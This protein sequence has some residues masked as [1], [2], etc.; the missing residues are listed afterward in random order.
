MAENESTCTGTRT[1]EG[2]ALSA[3]LAP[4]S[5]PRSKRKCAA[6]SRRWCGSLV[7]HRSPRVQCVYL[8]QCSHAL[9]LYACIYIC[10]LP[11]MDNNTYAKLNFEVRTIV[12]TCFIL[13]TPLCGAY[14]LL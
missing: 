7:P 5:T 12:T 13:L 1:E 3:I 8:T 4:P 14:E 11:Y 2:A 9:D 10:I 6:A